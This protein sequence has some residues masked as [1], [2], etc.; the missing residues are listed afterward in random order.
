[1]ALSQIFGIEAVQGLR[2]EPA[3]FSDERSVEIDLAAAIG[4]GL[5]HHHVPVYAR[6]VS[7]VRLLIG[8]TGREMEGA[9]NLFVE[10]GV[11]HRDLDV[12]VE[13]KGEFPDVS[14]AV[15]RIQ[16]VV[17]PFRV[18]RTGFND[19]SVLEP[20][21]NVVELESVVERGRVETDRSVH[22][23]PHGGRKSTLRP[24]R[25]FVPRRG[26]LGSLSC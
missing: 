3:I 5:D 23:R 14:R 13:P 16:N 22:R 15:I 2:E 7:V 1:M 17:E 19:L 11:Q 12:G 10:E 21:M 8:L 9:C 24:E 26:P 18:V 6:S 4:R 20:E 25:S